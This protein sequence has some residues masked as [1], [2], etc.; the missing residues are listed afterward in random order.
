MIKT[1]LFLVHLYQRYF[2][3]QRHCRIAIS[4]HAPYRMLNHLPAQLNHLRD[5]INT[6]DKTYI[7]QLQMDRNSFGRL[8]FILE[9]IGGL[10][11]TRNVQISEQVPI[12]LSVLAHHIKN[13]VVK[14]DF[15]RSGYTISIHFNV[16]LQTVLRLH[17]IL[18]V[19]P[20][21]VNHERTDDKW[22]WFKGC[23]GALDE[24][25]IDVRVSLYDKASWKGSAADCCV[26]GDGV[27][28]NNGLKVPN[29]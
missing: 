22:K 4:N 28:H 27:S 2:M 19:T 18:L 24:T 26:L 12:F 20:Q 25:Y 5:L 21:H 9:N 17:S 23:L 14:C 15:K 13:Y 3:C 10:A 29:G 11:H 8:C 7:E 6:S 16:M 1:F